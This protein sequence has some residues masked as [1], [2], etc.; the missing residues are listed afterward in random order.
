MVKKKLREF[1]FKTLIQKKEKHSKM[2]N[3]TY[4]DL[5]L[6]GYLKDE[7]IGVNQA[8]SVF[9]FR[10]RMARFWENFKGGRPPQPCPV[11]REAKSVD[12]QTHSFECGVVKENMA[13][14]AD[15]R[16]LFGLRVHENTAKI[17]ENIE[18]FR[19]QIMDK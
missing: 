6:Q 13:I 10:T 18:K 8:R 2:D 19:E 3:L 11:C 4:G 14:N 17:V 16:N 7:K 5:E 12:T 9:R 15:Y 1:A